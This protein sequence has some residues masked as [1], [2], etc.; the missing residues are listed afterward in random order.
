MRRIITTACLAPIW[1]PFLVVAMVWYVVLAI[2]Y[3]FYLLLWILLR[4][5]KS[6]TTG[7]AALPAKGDA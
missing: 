7:E 3:A 1:L 5:I 6:N 4:K 2:P